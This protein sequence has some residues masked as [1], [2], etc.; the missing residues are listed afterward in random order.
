MTALRQVTET[1]DRSPY[2]RGGWGE[3]EGLVRTAGWRT[4]RERAANGRA[5]RGRE[6]GAGGARRRRPAIWRTR[7]GGRFLEKVF[8]ARRWGRSPRVVAPG[9]VGS[10]WPRTNRGIPRRT[11]AEGVEVGGTSPIATRPRGPARRQRLVPVGDDASADGPLWGAA[12]R[13]GGSTRRLAVAV[14]GAAAPSNAAARHCPAPRLR[15]GVFPHARLERTGG[16]CANRTRLRRS[17]RQPPVISGDRR[18]APGRDATAVA[19]SVSD[20]RLAM[21]QG[22]RRI[23]STRSIR[24]ATVPWSLT[25]EEE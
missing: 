25:G 15:G 18:S 3:R 21:G 23:G 10:R 9:E 24:L 17:L 2:P 5:G 22:R 14:V 1:F 19:E 4:P 16:R 6:R 13:G 12:W 8:P 11:M 7:R 20:H